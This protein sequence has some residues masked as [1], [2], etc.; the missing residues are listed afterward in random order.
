MS[1]VYRLIISCPDQVGIV[2]SVA[3]YIAQ[4]GAT[5]VEANHHTDAS[6][7][8]FFMRHEILAT[9][10]KESLADFESGFADVASQFNMQWYLSDSE[11]PKKIA[12]FASKESHCLADLLHRWHESEL[13]GQVVCVVA[14]HD[15]LRS[16]VEWHKVPFH[17]VPVYHP[18]CVAITP[19]KSLIFIT[20]S[21]PR[22]S[23]PGLIIKQTNE[24]SS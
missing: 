16:M 14:N 2:A 19:V 1:R 10:L 23:G 9:S 13:P 22:L 7:G 21:C 4:K 5:I 24:G 3:S 18:K 8:W 6:N 17:Y 11:S 20:A 15:D 12:L